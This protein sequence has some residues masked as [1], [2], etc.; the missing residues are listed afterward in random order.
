MMTPSAKRQRSAFTLIELLV[1]I[2][3][4]A[5]LAAILFPVFAQ[6]REKAR[7][8][9]CLSNAKQ[10]GLAMTMYMTDYDGTVPF[11]RETLDG[12]DWW[13]A[14]MISWKD[15]VY[16][17][18]KNGGYSYNNGVAYSTPGQ[19]GVFA[20]M[21]NGSQWGTAKSFGFAGTGNGDETSRFPRSYAINAY[22]GCNEMGLSGGYCPNFWPA[23]GDG[24][25]T[26]AESTLQNPASTIL[27]TETRN[28]LNDINPYYTT[29]ECT[30]EGADGG[31]SGIS[32]VMNHS[33]IVN[34]VFF[35]G[36][37]KGIKGP[38]AVQDDL[39]DSFG[40]NG[41][42]AAEAKGII[43]GNSAHGNSTPVSSMRDW[44]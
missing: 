11:K 24:S 4:I 6:A 31:G 2:A 38:R 3:I 1:V 9:S 44:R 5:I 27:I 25:G 19:G 13:T 35:D 12:G 33:G 29:F 20:C 32:Y 8:A 39:W 23:V 26:G 43:N 40:T 17:Y 37:A 36:H 7:Q 21:S 30:P 41:L 18:I 10:M 15:L 14:R 34:F 16:P 22:A 28:A 42:G